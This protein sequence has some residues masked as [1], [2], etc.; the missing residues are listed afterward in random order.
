VRVLLV[1]DHA[2]VRDGIRSLLVANNIEVVSE[3]ADGLE[4]LE[5]AQKLHPEIILMDI[6]MPRCSGLEATRLIKTEMPETKVIIL[7]VSDNDD[8]LFEAIKNGAAGYL[9]KNIKGEEFLSFLHRVTKDEAP[10]SSSMATKII[11]EFARQSKDKS[12][13]FATGSALKEREI[14]ILRLVSSGAL[15]KEIALALHISENTVKYH[16]KNTMD[17]LHMRNRAELASYAERK[18]LTGN[19]SKQ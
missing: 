4:A 1:D 16:L 12:E 6:Q 11:D 15:N 7:T 14:E 8:D 10:I 18:G 2:L 19:S 5:K 9:L 3:A 13:Q 17:K